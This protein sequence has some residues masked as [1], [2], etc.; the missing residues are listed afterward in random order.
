MEHKFGQ[1]AALRI[2]LALV[3][4]ADGCWRLWCGW[5]FANRTSEVFEVPI[6]SATSRSRAVIWSSILK[7]GE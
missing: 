6:A 3:P 7:N 4:S 5:Y 2:S 1:E